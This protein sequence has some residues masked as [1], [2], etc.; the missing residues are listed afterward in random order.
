LN[1]TIGN[2]DTLLV[3]LPEDDIKVQIYENQDHLHLTSRVALGFILILSAMSEFAFATIH[4]MYLQWKK[5]IKLIPEEGT[6]AFIYYRDI[7]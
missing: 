2:N 6:N 3:G 5:A 7:C 4:S 1:N